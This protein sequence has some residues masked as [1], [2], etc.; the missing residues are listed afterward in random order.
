[1]VVFV[2]L[3]WINTMLWV[4]KTHADSFQPMQVA[5]PCIEIEHRCLK[6]WSVGTF[7][8]LF[9]SD[10]DLNSLVQMQSSL[11]SFLHSLQRQVQVKL[12]EVLSWSKHLG[13]HLKYGEKA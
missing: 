5:K 2:A 13:E 12:L 9:P 7:N 4:L 1:M 8:G 11:I 10:L 6:S 3:V